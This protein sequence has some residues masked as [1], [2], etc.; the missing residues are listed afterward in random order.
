MTELHL[1]D[2]S[3]KVLKIGPLT[4]ELSLVHG[5]RLVGKFFLSRRKNRYRNAK[6]ARHNRCRIGITDLGLKHFAKIS[7][8]RRKR[9]SH[10]LSQ[11][12]NIEKS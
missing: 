9:L 10:G 7:S 8:M 4:I 6:G 12:M 2:R 5:D 1:F 11:R 3:Y